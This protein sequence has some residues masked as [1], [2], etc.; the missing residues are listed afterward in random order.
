MLKKTA[1]YDYKHYKKSCLDTKIT[2]K[3]LDTKITTQSSLN[4]K[5]NRWPSLNT[6]IT[7]HSLSIKQKSQ[8]RNGYKCKKMQNSRV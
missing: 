6:K 5:I 8:D 1:I 2:D 4:I 3:Y 7:R